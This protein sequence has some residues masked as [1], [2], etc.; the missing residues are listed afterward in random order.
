[1]ETR[2]TR[3]TLA[4]LVI[5]QSGKNLQPCDNIVV[6]TVVAYRGELC[7]VGAVR[8]TGSAKVHRM[9]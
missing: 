5:R 8:R 1:M 9:E 6:T 2:K 4:I 7:I 3:F